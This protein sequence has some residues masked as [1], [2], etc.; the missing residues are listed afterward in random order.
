MDNRVF[1]YGAKATPPVAPTAPSVGY[2]TNGDPVNNTPATQPGDF[3]FYQ[4]GEEVR[5]AQVENGLAPSTA[6]LTQ[7]AKAISTQ[8]IGTATRY[9]QAAVAGCSVMVEI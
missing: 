9:R 4:L 2:P 1:Q 3:W 7:L 8:S 5:A 6:D